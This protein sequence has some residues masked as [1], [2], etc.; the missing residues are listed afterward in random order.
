MKEALKEAHKATKK[1]EVPVGAIVVKEG[2]IIGRGHNLRESLNDPTAHAEI[3]AIKRAARKLKNWRL[4]GCALYVTVEP[5]IMCAGAIL[6]ARLE[7]VVYG[8]KD[9]KSGAV[10][11][12]YEVLADQR[13]NHRVKEIIGG[14]L[15]E[16]C[17]TIL[18]E[19]FKSLRD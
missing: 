11:S 13:L 4:N 19:F 10:S 5:C 2:K 15:E 9:P 8:A 18:R 17:T 7:K 12:L 1:N 6:L 16:E 3:I 14:I